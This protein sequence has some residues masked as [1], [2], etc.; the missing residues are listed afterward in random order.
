MLG[1]VLLVAQCHVNT[2]FTCRS[3]SHRTINSKLIVASVT[4]DEPPREL[5][6]AE[7]SALM[8]YTVVQSQPAS[9]KHDLPRLHVRA[10]PHH[11]SLRPEQR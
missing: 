4:S 6:S 2:R 8:A 1:A 3:P 7:R 5:S 9:T 11:V 10:E